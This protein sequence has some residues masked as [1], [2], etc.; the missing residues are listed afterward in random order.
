MIPSL[1]LRVLTPTRQA[2]GA[3]FDD[4]TRA[5]VLSSS[6]IICFVSLRL[7]VNR[8][9]TGAGSLFACA[10]ATVSSKPNATI[11]RPISHNGC[12]VSIES[13][14]AAPPSPAVG[15]KSGSRVAARRTAL[16]KLPADRSPAART[17]LTD[18]LTAADGGMRERKRS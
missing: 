10:N 1:P 4:D 14:S 18:S 2:A 5:P 17:R 13:F 12:E 8:N 15:S 9:A 7:G 11:Q 6:S 3:I 16:A